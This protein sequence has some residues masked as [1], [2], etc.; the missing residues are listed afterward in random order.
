M[1]E[2]SRHPKKHCDERLRLMTKVS[3]QLPKLL[4]WSHKEW[5]KS[6]CEAPS[7]TRVPL[8]SWSTQRDC[9]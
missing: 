9:P 2:K 6:I 3:V 4:S 7:A 1:A 5:N 8:K